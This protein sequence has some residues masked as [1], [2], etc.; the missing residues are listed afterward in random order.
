MDHP[1]L[2]AI[3]VDTARKINRRAFD[4]LWPALLG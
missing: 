1:K 4:A 2:R 3:D